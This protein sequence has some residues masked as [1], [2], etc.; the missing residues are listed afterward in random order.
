MSWWWR[1][2][3]WLR[4]KVQD[5]YS[6]IEFNNMYELKIREYLVVASNERFQLWLIGNDF[7]NGWSR[8]CCAGVLIVLACVDDLSD[9]Y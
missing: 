4:N 8:T 2:L 5:A 1:G 3:Y 9:L 7:S 6:G